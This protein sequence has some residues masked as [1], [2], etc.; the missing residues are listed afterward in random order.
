MGEGMFPGGF[1]QAGG[2]QS[3][4]AAE[5][6]AL[7]VKLQTKAQV[8]AWGLTYFLTK[9]KMPALL[10]FYA[11]LNRMPRD[12]QLDRTLVL[13]TF[14]R[15]FGLMDRNK[16]DEIDK[17]AFAQFAR[18]WTDFLKYYATWGQDIMLNAKS[19]DPSQGGTAGGNFG[20]YPGGYPGGPG[21]GYPGA[22]G[23]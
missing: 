7:K 2:R 13:H 4:P 18:D 17:E 15:S 19:K 11:E 16:P 9:K 6:R 1:P 22:G 20:G 8:T 14:C 10:K 21:G 5:K 23:P 3:D 12:T